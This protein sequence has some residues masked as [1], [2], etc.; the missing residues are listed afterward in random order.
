MN[1]QTFLFW[2]GQK[3]ISE[4]SSNDLRIAGDDFSK[5]E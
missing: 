2:V 4:L 5:Q 3:N 1:D